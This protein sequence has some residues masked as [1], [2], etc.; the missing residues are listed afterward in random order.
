MEMRGRS[1]WGMEAERREAHLHSCHTV[2][3][4]LETRESCGYQT[5]LYPLDARNVGSHVVA[6]LWGLSNDRDLFFFYDPVDSC[7]TM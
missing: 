7:L 2:L 1:L 5:A 4:R 6:G 3:Y